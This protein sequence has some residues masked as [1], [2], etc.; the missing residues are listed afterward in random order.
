MSPNA[1]HIK[2]ALAASHGEH[3]ARSMGCVRAGEYV[4]LHTHSVSF[5]SQLNVIGLDKLVIAIAYSATFAMQFVESTTMLI[6][7]KQNP[8][9]CCDCHLFGHR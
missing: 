9:V 3:C 1:E 8:N 2:Y 6:F 5:I 4:A 7:P